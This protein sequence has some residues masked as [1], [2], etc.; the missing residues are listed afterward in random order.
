MALTVALSD[1]VRLEV[2]FVKPKVPLVQIVKAKGK[3]IFIS[4]KIFLKILTLLPHVNSLLKRHVETLGENTEEEVRLVVKENDFFLV[5][6]KFRGQSYVGFHTY[7][8]GVRN[9]CMNI[10]KMEWAT[11]CRN[12]KIIRDGLSPVSPE[13][14]RKGRAYSW[15][16]LDE[17]GRL[18]HEDDIW[19]Y[20]ADMSETRASE[21]RAENGI[22]DSGE[23]ESCY[24][25]TE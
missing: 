17:S 10:N 16:L 3:Q 7:R 22:S 14:E 1:D 8:N 23:S 9:V 12:E 24:S 21:Y 4:G 20:L 18:L 25:D 15:A 11:L 2:K 6:S 19:C 5:V 13:S